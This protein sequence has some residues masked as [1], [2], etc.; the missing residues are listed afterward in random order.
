[1][2]CCPTAPAVKVSVDAPPIEGPE[3]TLRPGETA[4]CFSQRAGNSTG[5]LDDTVT[6]KNK[7]AIEAVNSDCQAKINLQF[8]LTDGSDATPITWDLSGDAVPGVSLS[9]TGLLS[10]TFD[11]SIHDKKLTITIKASWP[12]AASDQSVGDERTYSFA[13]GLCKGGDSI[14]LLKPL[15]N[16]E[17]RSPFGMRLHPIQKVMKLHTGIDLVMPTKGVHGDVFAAADGVCIKSKNTDPNG[18]GLAVHIK[19]TNSSG[20][21]LCTTTYNHL[22][23]SLV[24][25]G[26][27]VSAGQKIALEGG[28]K[29]DPGSGGSTG[30]HLHFEVKLPNGS[31]TDPVPYLTGSVNVQSQAEG[32]SATTKPPTGAAV[33]SSDVAAKTNCPASADYPKDAAA[34]E[35]AAEAAPVPTNASTDPFEQAWFFT[36][37]YEV[38]PHWNVPAGTVPTD[39]EIVAGLCDT[40]AQKHKCGYKMWISS[41][42]GETK[43]GIA[44]SGNP[45]TDIKAV[46]YQACKDLGYSNYWKR[47]KIVPATLAT[48]S[49]APYLAVFMFDTNYQHGS[50]NARTIWEDSA[51]GSSWPDKAAQLVALDK[52]FARRLSFANTLKNVAD[53]K[54]VANRVNACY[55][56]VKS[57]NF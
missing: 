4:E 32:V 33:T 46:T 18:Y 15:A 45:S 47:G 57:L 48:T 40:P 23:R 50:G 37:K 55:A 25:E 24:S 42:G 29:G 7:I 34:P 43:F 51:V 19:H 16:G 54:G 21:H 2:S 44:K 52:L 13:P 26:D 35:P 28:L 39:P 10:G 30:L 5:A 31:F 3:Q 27:K 56:Y 1:M 41:S 11:S 53:R 22:Y 12:A 38:G 9:A 20:A 8:K 14:K 49:N 6:P 17:I 36:M